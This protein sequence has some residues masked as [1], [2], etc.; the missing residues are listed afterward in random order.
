MWPPWPLTRHTELL[1]SRCARCGIDVEVSS[2][3]HFNNLFSSSL[4]WEE[5]AIL[6]L[7]TKKK[8]HFMF[9]YKFLYLDIIHNIIVSLFIIYLYLIVRNCWRL[10]L[11]KA[12][13]EADE[14]PDSDSPFHPSLHPSIPPFIIHIYSSFCSVFQCCNQQD[15]PPAP[16]TTVPA[17]LHSCTYST[18]SIPAP[19]GVAAA[20][21]SVFDVSLSRCTRGTSS[22]S[23]TVIQVCSSP[24]WFPQT[25][26]PPWLILLLIT[27]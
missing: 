13:E 27:I 12:S 25:P 7:A 22:S 16:I 24:C 10:Q 11:L 5:N 9:C 3:P 20:A 18:L 21:A 4:H 14:C 15:K 6:S 8:S 17:P 19:P 23:M 1:V 26:F 2:Q